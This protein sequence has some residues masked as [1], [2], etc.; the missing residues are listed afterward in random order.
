MPTMNTGPRTNIYKVIR[1]SNR[2][3]IMFNHNDRI[4]KIAELMQRL[5]QTSI[6]A[7]MKTDGRFIQN[8]QRAN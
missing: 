1:S 2:I 8:I 7:L 6:V 5:H 4:P 3:F